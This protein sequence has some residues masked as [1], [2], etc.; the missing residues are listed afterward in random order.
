LAAF[1][2]VGISST[3]SANAI[4]IGLLQWVVTNTN[5]PGDGQFS[6]VNQTGPVGNNSQ[7]PDFPVLTQILFNGDMNLAVNFTSGPSANLTQGDMTS[8]D[9]GHSWDTGVF[10]PNVLPIQAILTGTVSPTGAIS[11]G[12]FHDYSTNEDFA[13][14]SWTISDNSLFTIPAALGDNATPIVD[15]DLAIIYV[16]ADQAATAVPEPATMTLLGTGIAGLIARRR[17]SRSA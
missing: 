13:A 9:G 2:I 7:P 11:L 6:I 1:A 14:G 8:P 12:A 5:A 16:N 17:K 4:P 3:A 15:G 10:G